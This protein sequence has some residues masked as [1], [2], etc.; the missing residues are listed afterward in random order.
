MTSLAN[1]SLLINNRDRIISLV[2]GLL[3]TDLFSASMKARLGPIANEPSIIELSDRSASELFD[4]L[5]LHQDWSGEP[6]VINSVDSDR[7]VEVP[8]SLV[9][10]LAARGVWS[11]PVHRIEKVLRQVDLSSIHAPNNPGE[12]RRLEAITAASQVKMSWQDIAI[13]YSDPTHRRSARNLAGTPHE[14]F[15]ELLCGG[16]WRGIAEAL[17][18]VPTIMALHSKIRGAIDENGQPLPVL[19]DGQIFQLRYNLEWFCGVFPEHALFRNAYLALSSYKAG[20][21]VRL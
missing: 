17:Y 10:I 12:R 16:R 5:A 15:E 11:Q 19:P 8:L 1:T 6:L 18:Y 21:G 4:D 3:T 20:K 9:A 2:Q 13:A 7:Q 14:M